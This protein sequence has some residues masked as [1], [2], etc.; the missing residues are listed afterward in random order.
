MINKLG[1][2]QPQQATLLTQAV[3]SGPWTP[4]SKQQLLSAIAQKLSG[5]PSTEDLYQHLEENF[6]MFLPDKLYQS[7]QTDAPCV[8]TVMQDCANTVVNLGMFFASEQTKGHVVKT[9]LEAANIPT[10][11]A[12]FFNHLSMF[13]RKYTVTTSADCTRITH[14]LYTHIHRA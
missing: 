2:L 5:A 9:A 6:A 11:S 4:D 12:E 7:W 8:A 14:A 3:N 10:T 13:K 1:S